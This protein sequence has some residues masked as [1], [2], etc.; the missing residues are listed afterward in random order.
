MGAGDPDVT[1]AAGEAGARKPLQ[2][3]TYSGTQKN[4]NKFFTY[5]PINKIS[6]YNPWNTVYIYFV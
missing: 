6:D 2:S 5:S 1:R 4:Y 3:W